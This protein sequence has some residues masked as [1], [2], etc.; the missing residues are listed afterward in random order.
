MFSLEA[1]GKINLTLDVLGKRP[2]GYHEVEMIMQSIELADV[3]HFSLRDDGEIVLI[4]EVEGVDDSKDNLIYKAA[5]KLKDLYKVAKGAQIILEKN[6]PVAAGLAGGSADA[7][8]TLQGLN[9]LWE[10]NLPMEK[11]CE[12]GAELGSDI[13]FCLRGG[14][15]LAQGRGEVLSSLP[16]MPECYVVLAKP[17]VGVSTAWVYG[18][19][20]GDKIVAHPKTK[21]VVEELTKKNLEGVADLLCNVLESVTIKKYNEIAELKE[22]MLEFGARASLMS[23]SGPTVFGLVED[24]D[25]AE[26]LA[27]ELEKIS[28][29]R[30]I[31]TRTV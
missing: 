2:D 31:V 23:G 9:K 30:I 5:V 15:M 10:L 17:N 28:S 8:T 3:L 6:I 21:M 13:P 4:S 12:I 29:A 27:R 1:R 16:V 25:K 26:R 20:D 19:Y 11:L 24:K 7:A 14:T 18:N 22:K